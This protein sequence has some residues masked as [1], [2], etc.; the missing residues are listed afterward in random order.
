MTLPP[1]SR[2]AGSGGSVAGP[3]MLLVLTTFPDAEGAGRV[4]RD[5]VERGLA[6]CVSIGAPIRSIYRW[7]EAVEEAREVPLTIKTTAAACDALMRALRDAHPYEVPE[8][9]ALPVERGLEAYLQ[10][11]A[12][13]TQPGEAGPAMR[14]PAGC[15]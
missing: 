2:D 6:A 4:G 13:V 11:V 15:R 9:I 10:W 12:A 7:R 8:I 1:S 14:S 3:R 5:L